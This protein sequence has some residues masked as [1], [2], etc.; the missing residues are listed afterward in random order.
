MGENN[1][2]YREYNLPYKSILIIVSNSVSDF[3]VGLLGKHLV[4]KGYGVEIINSVPPWIGIHHDLI[5]CS[6]PNHQICDFLLQQTVSGKP[7]IVDMDDDFF[8]IPKT[9]P[10]YNQLGPGNPKYLEKLKETLAKVTK[11][12]V[13]SDE[14]GSRFG[15]EYQV[16]KNY[17]D[18]SNVLWNLPRCTDPFVIGWTG[19]TTHR[20]DFRLVEKPLKD[21]LNDYP[22]SKVVIGVD[23]EIYKRFGDFPEDRKLFIPGMP[24]DTYPCFFSFC[25]LILSPLIDDHFNKAKSDIKLLEANAAGK[26]WIASPIL[27]YLEYG[28]IGGMFAAD[29]NSW[30]RHMEQFVNNPDFA[31]IYGAS[32][33]K[34]AWERTSKIVADFWVSLIE[35]I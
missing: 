19:T 17:F 34:F 4:D 6:R 7:V 23:Q 1:L 32:G 22:N 27:P 8:S 18:E 35:V 29:E 14:I 2:I 31:T 3:R 24:Y 9:N 16:I 30:Y 26:P 21:I 15:R 25:D 13:T 5:I 12:V 33:K 11:L 20:E 28:D 10:A